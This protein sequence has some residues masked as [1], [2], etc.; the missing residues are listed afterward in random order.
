MCERICAL[1]KLCILL[2][3]ISNLV[4]IVGKCLDALLG[5]PVAV[6]GCPCRYWEAKLSA[7]TF[8]NAIEVKRCVLAALS[9]WAAL[10]HCILMSMYS[11][12]EISVRSET[13]SA[14]SGGR[15]QWS[16]FGQGHHQQDQS[17]VRFVLRSVCLCVSASLSTQR[18]FFCPAALSHQS[19]F[20]MVIQV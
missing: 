12:L 11:S 20:C 16:C 15:P 10:I 18:S 14:F 8:I 3:S 9:W 17:T 7:W 1:V 19:K 6:V 4:Y 13:I 5:P 2:S